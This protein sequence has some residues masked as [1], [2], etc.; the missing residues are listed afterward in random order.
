MLPSYTLSADI[1]FSESFVPRPSTMMSRPVALGSSVPQ[2]PTFLI[3]KRRLMASSTSCEVGPAG[4]SIRSAP[5]NGS[6]SCM[7]LLR[8]VEGL[9]YCGDHPT[10]N[11][12]RFAAEARAGR[13]RVSAAA[14]QT[15]DFIDIHPL[16][17]R[18]QA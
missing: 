14:E 9:F 13:G 12:Q 18:A 11:G 15:G 4:L 2:W 5:S 10:L 7:G 8:R 3:W 16:A 1:I 17:F 6:N